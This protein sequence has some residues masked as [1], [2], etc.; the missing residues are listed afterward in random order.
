MANEHDTSRGLSSKPSGNIPPPP[1]C[2]SL[3]LVNANA[4]GQTGSSG[5]SN[6]NPFLDIDK[7]CE[8]LS[9][10]EY[11]GCYHE[12]R[13]LVPPTAI[14]NIKLLRM[15]RDTSHPRVYDFKEADKVF[16]DAIL[17]CLRTRIKRKEAQKLN[18]EADVME[19]TKE[20][21]KASEDLGAKIFLL[22]ASNN[23]QGDDMS[24]LE[25]RSGDLTA[26]NARKDE[27]QQAQSSLNGR[28]DE[29][30]TEAIAQD[31][32]WKQYAERK[33]SEISLSR[34]PPILNPSDRLND[35]PG[36]CKY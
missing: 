3:K 16:L 1:I 26:S 24:A 9:P 14:V 27:L 28:N 23:E 36:G 32:M 35:N 33:G 20:K 34:L 4:G 21:L 12:A 10:D 7:A 19:T 22:Q 25:R 29:R 30:Q 31:P 2:P 15:L 18:D 5:R 11:E 8:K 13:R 6:P 17:L